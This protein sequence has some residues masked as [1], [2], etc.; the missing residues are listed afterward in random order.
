MTRFQV[1]KK[2]LRFGL[3]TLRPKGWNTTN[4]V[5]S[6]FIKRSSIKL[7]TVGLIGIA[8]VAIA[9]PSQA[10]SITT[11]FAGGNGFS[12]NM[13][14]VTTFS[15]DLVVESLEIN[16]ST[17]GDFFDV[18]T[19]SG[20]YVGSETNP[21]D[22][23]LV[24]STFLNLVSPGGTPTFVDVNDFILPGNSTTGLYVTFRNVSGVN[25]T[26]GANTYSNADLRLDLGVGKAP[27][28]GSTFRP[29]TWNGTINY[30]AVPEPLTILGTLTAVGF[31]AAFRRKS[32]FKNS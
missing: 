16:A 7:S 19:K 4:L 30:E 17:G 32:A 2:M 5:F 25:Y 28:F 12:G 29:R 20:T 13:F 31:G 3:E 21:A 22:W 1:R 11:T 14:D 6:T 9:S 15:N 27:N 24:S 26:N 18:Y 10:A 23:T 8:S